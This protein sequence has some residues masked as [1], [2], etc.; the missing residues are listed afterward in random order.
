MLLYK[1][2]IISSE[3]IRVTWLSL[4]I[5]KILSSSNSSFVTYFI[6]FVS[7][8][9]LF[10]I[11]FVFALA[12]TILL[13]NYNEYG[14][15]QFDNKSLIMINSKISNDEFKKGELIVTESK[16]VDEYKEGEYVFTYK[17]GPDRIPT[18]VVGKIGNIYPEEEAITFE[19]GETYSVENIA[20]TPYKKYDKI[21]GILSLIE[22]KWGFLFIVLI[23]VFLIFIYEVYA[24][25]IEIKYGA[26]ED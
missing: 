26:E 3:F 1:S 16:K 21:G 9:V 13:L 25:I 7:I 15:T 20:G 5:F 12:M 10:G 22:S 24:L 23:P 2:E 17:I 18:V 11:Y 4:N 19:N 14:I 6:S 8:F